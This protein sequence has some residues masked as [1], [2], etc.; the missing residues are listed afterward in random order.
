[1]GLRNFMFS[2]SYAHIDNI[3]YSKQ[4][5][6]VRFELV[7]FENETKQREVRRIPYQ[8]IARRDATNVSDFVQALPAEPS[9]G[10]KVVVDFGDYATVRAEF[11]AFERI[12]VNPPQVQTDE[13][14]QTTNQAELDAYTAL[15]NSFDRLK[16][17]NKRIA[18]WDGESEQW[19]FFQPADNSLIKNGSQRYLFRNN[20]WLEDAEVFDQEAFESRFGLAQMN[21]ENNNIVALSYNW[22]KT[23]PECANTLDA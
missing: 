19:V 11:I 7:L 5:S 8:L 16:E 22:L 23:M 3:L 9:A 4:Q 17:Q 6:V 10:D 15:M 13:T 14:G 21:G 12:R 1:M 2:G 18:I 20:E